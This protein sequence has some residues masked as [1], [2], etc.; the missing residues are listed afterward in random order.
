MSYYH[1]CISQKQEEIMALTGKVMPE[2]APMHSGQKKKN[3]FCISFKEVAQII[4]VKEKE[5]K[6]K[7]KTS[8]NSTNQQFALPSGK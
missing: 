1:R 3:K 7:E 4:P 2:E 8:I 6:I 5:K